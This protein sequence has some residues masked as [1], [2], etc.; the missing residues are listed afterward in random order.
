MTEGINQDHLTSDEVLKLLSF[1]SEYQPIV[2]GGQSVNIWSQLFQGKDDEL[3]EL[4]ALT[5]KDLDFF[6]NQKAQEALAAN[7]IEGKLFLPSFDDHTPSA[8]VVIG[9]IGDKQVE[10]DF[11][12]NVQGVDDKSLRKNSVTFQYDGTDVSVTLMHPLDC[13]RSRLANINTLRRKSQHSLNQAFASVRIL[14]CFIDH[15]LAGGDK[16]GHR[17]ATDAL[18]QLEFILRDDHIG[19]VSDEEFGDFL[20][21]SAILYRYN[22]DERLDARYREHQLSGIIQRTEDRYHVRDKRRVSA[23]KTVGTDSDDVD[24]DPA[25]RG[26]KLK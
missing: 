20:E 5:S 22:N 18:D 21:I 14:D 9:K 15:G 24:A 19:K 11:L 26:T 16:V 3:D 12:S 10:I 1:V 2:V 13:V 17:M 7:L 6:Q 4:G 23:N 25:V 8:S